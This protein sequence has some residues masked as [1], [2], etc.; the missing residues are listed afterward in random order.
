[1]DVSSFYTNIDHEESAEACFKGL[2]EREDKSIPSIV[3]KN[4]NLMILES[5][6]FRFDNESYRQITDTAMGTPIESNY[7]NSFMDN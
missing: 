5:Y 2:D 3:I 1:M 6:A 7:A 4:L